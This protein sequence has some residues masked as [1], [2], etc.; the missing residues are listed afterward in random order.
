MNS[1]IDL[2][3]TVRTHRQQLTT[4]QQQQASEA[5]KQRLIKHDKVN[6]AKRI[7]LYLA[8]DSEL[9]TLSFI[10][11]CWQQDKEVYLPVLHPFCSG[12]LLFLR[13]QQDT[14]M[15]KNK[16]NILEPVLDVTQVCPI[17]LLDILFTPLVAFDKTG[18]RLGMGGG[19]YDRTLAGWHKEQIM[20]P[21]N[22]DALKLYPIGIAHDCQR[23]KSI[24]TEVWDIPLPEIITPSKTYCF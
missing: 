16:Y 12:H 15:T 7:A 1:R 3:K 5:F 9:D 14:A 22:A 21:I 2:R 20:P 13:Y 18:A 8:N 23:V 24:P 17:S 6:K 10:H 4:V 11:W 19:F